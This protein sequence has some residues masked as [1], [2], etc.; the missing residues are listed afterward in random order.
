MTPKPKSQIGDILGIGGSVIGGTIGGV[1]SGGNPMGILQGASLGGKVGGTAGGAIASANAKPEPIQLGQHGG[2]ME[3][4]ASSQDGT[5]LKSVSSAMDLIHHLPTGGPRE[6]AGKSLG[7][8]LR[9]GWGLNVNTN[10]GVQPFPKDIGSDIPLPEVPN[11][12]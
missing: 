8:A 10:L 6:E 7:E 4:R 11:F 9:K 1:L 3:R 12:T 2:A 5:A